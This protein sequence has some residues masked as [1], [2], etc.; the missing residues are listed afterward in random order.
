MKPGTERYPDEPEQPQ[1]GLRIC[2]ENLQAPIHFPVKLA[3]RKPEKNEFDLRQGVNLVCS[4]PDP[5]GVLH[6]AYEDFRFFFKSVGLSAAGPCPIATVQ[7]KTTIF[8]EYRIDIRKDRIVIAA[9][10]TEGVRR[11]LIHLE[12]EIL[13]RGTS[14]LTVKV[15]KR[16]PVIRTR[17]SRCFYGPINRPPKCQDELADNVDYYPDGYLNRL[18]HHG[19]N[20]LWLTIKFQDICPS[21]II[22]EY[23]QNSAGH[24]E[25]LRRTIR[26]CARY[27][28]KI[29]PFCI[30]PASFPAG[31]PILKAHPKLKGHTQRESGQAAFCTSSDL[32]RAYLEEAT[33]ILFSEAPGLGGLIVIPVG[34]RLTHCYSW[35]LPESG[36]P[37]GKPNNCPR[38]SQRKPHEVLADTLA[39]MER[40]MRSVDSKAELI[41]WPYAQSLCWGTELMTQTAGR[42]PEN[43]ILQHNFE[44]G[45]RIKQLGKWRPLWD[46]WLSWP[47]PS[48]LFADCAHSAR[49][50]GTRI[51]AK[52]QTSCS[53][54]VTTTQYVPVPGLIYQKHKKMHALGVSGAMQGWY[55]GTY[56]ALMTKASGI[57]AFAPFPKSEREFLMALARRDWGRYAP[58]V[59]KAWECFRKGY[60]QYPGEHIFGYYGPMHDGS[61]WPLY[62]KP[63]HLPL[64]PNWKIGYPTSG[65]A[66]GECVAS[67]F[68]YPE[69]L[70]L[71]KRMRD[72][73]RRGLNILYRLEPGLRAQGRARNHNKELL[74]EIG[75]A[76]ALGLQFESGYNILEFYFLRDKLAFA[77]ISPQKLRLLDALR[78]LVRKEIDNS[79]GLLKLCRKN[80]LLGFSSEAEGYKY[81]PDKLTWRLNQLKKL[82]AVE[83]QNIEKQVRNGLALFP[84]YT[85]LNPSTQTYKCLRS[86]NGEELTADPF[87]TKWDA[88]PQA[89]CDFQAAK[90][91]EDAARHYP[92]GDPMY[93]IQAREV[94]G[95]ERQLC[96]SIEPRRLELPTRDQLS[97]QLAWRSIFDRQAIYF[98]F[99]GFPGTA[100]NDSIQIVFEPNRIGPR[101]AFEILTDGTTASMTGDGFT[102]AVP[103][104]WKV[105]AQ[106]QN[107]NRRITLAVPF[108]CLGLKAPTPANPSRLRLN[109]GCFLDHRSIFHSWAKTHFVIPRLIFDYIHPATFGWLLFDTAG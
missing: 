85:G 102:A 50:N 89:L 48:K 71:C 47:G 12:D 86:A 101:T 64:A 65:D 88:Y 97:A 41:A 46:Y 15:I 63:R 87:S 61:V 27:G 45:G 105:N 68:T 51:F 90:R 6:A 37:W 55:F 73:W 29:Y 11:G 42:M 5:A 62:L 100:S 83:F 66:M 107:G 49:K 92:Y 80:P 19:I 93:P 60:S 22:P 36:H 104:G 21:K 23:G 95:Q 98:C 39:A 10:D 74:C 14:C 1:D 67:N 79:R 56:P 58:D 84:D 70:T 35:F 44:T 26:Q 99:S 13:T 8:E 75:V 96:R 53:H 82:L 76:K 81:F 59:A 30:E 43:V 109:V 106:E 2:E 52:L 77:K 94:R 4:F 32:G 24:L 9:A 108:A 57:L 91:K 72:H 7:T 20:A 34:E 33:H 38:C 28:I 103:A 3:A 40:G 78:A 16:R 69:I 54:E 25:K 18:A 31:S 17:I